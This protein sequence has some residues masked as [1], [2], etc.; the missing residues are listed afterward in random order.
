[1]EPVEHMGI[2]GCPLAQ[3]VSTLVD[4]GEFHCFDLYFV[5]WWD[6][7]SLGGDGEASVLDVFFSCCLL[8]FMQMPT[9]VASNEI[10]LVYH[11]DPWCKIHLLHLVD[12]WLGISWKTTLGNTLRNTHDIYIYNII[13]YIHHTD[14]DHEEKSHYQTHS[15]WPQSY[16][17]NPPNSQI[18]SCF[19]R[20]IP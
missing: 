17:D 9:H 16:F 20:H 12:L 15:I 10:G 7:L 3:E 4:S 2:R 8:L 11:V 5:H 13:I 6:D 18:Q 14:T 1:M 19:G